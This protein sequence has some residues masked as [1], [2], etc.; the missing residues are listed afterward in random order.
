MHSLVLVSMSLLAN[1]VEIQEEAIQLGS[2]HTVS[3]TGCTPGETVLLLSNDDLGAGVCP[4]VLGGSCVDL[5][6]RPLQLGSAV[7]DATGVAEFPLAMPTCAPWAGTRLQAVQMGVVDVSAPLDV[8]FEPDPLL[9]WPALV[10]EPGTHAQYPFDQAP[11]YWDPWLTNDQVDQVDAWYREGTGA[12]LEDD[13]FQSLDDGHSGIDSGYWNHVEVLGHRGGTLPVLERW[14]LVADGVTWSV[15]S[16]GWYDDGRGTPLV[17]GAQYSY[18][19]MFMDTGDFAWMYDD[20]LAMITPSVDSY[21]GEGD[22]DKMAYLSPYY[23]TS[24]GMS[25][26][27]VDLSRSMF[28]ASAALHPALKDRMMAT[29]TYI[30]TLQW[31]LKRNYAADYRSADAHKAAYDWAAITNDVAWQMVLDAHDLDHIPPIPQ[32]A[33]VDS[34]HPVALSDTGWIISAATSDSLGTVEL[35]VDASGSYTDTGGCITEYSWTLLR[36]D[37]GVVMTPLTVDGSKMQFEIPWQAD[38]HRTDI[39]LIVNDGTM[40]GP[41]AYISIDQRYGMNY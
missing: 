14:N 32:M 39:V 37:E 36:G 29:G 26:T 16:Y 25:Y 17:N 24:E 2:S 35:T 28:W 6:W 9:A 41:P 19:M 8:F 13:V 15:Q 3:V 40:D 23:L 22:S 5:P 21:K 38:A 30:P 12:G 18:T 1:A 10:D 20:N 31:L 4:A 7:A 33:L 34:N 11:Y 27:D